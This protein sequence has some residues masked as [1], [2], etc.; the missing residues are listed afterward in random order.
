M[1]IQL[2]LPA[3][4]AREVA[5]RRDPV[6]EL[7]QL[8]RDKLDAKVEIRAALE[9]VAEKH[10]IPISEVNAAVRGYAEDMLSDLT[11]ELERELTRD[12]EARD[13]I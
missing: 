2:P 3:G 9:H 11:Y 6:A 8:A 10:G 12:V 7:D 1:S 5:S 13:I 4:W